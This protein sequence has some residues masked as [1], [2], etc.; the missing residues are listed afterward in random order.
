[1][2]NNTRVEI[3]VIGQV[4]GVFFRASAKKEA[5]QLGISG[6]ITNEPDGSVTVQAEGSNSA[7]SQFLDWCRVGSPSAKVR[8]LRMKEIPVKHDKSFEVH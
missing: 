5:D 4:Q 7:I 2:T 1:M 3:K 6:F 8:D